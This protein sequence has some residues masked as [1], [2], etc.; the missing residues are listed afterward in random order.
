MTATLSTITGKSRTIAVEPASFAQFTLTDSQPVD[1]ARA[2]A[3]PKWTLYCLDIPSRT[4]LFIDVA[5]G[6]DLA[7]APFA[8]EAQFQH[9]TQAL[10]V[11]FAAFIATA[12]SQDPPEKLLLIFSTG[13]CGSTLFS[14]VLAAMPGV[15][16]LSEPDAFTNLAL[17]GAGLSQGDL[18]DLLKAAMAH[19]FRPPARHRIFAPKFRSEVFSQIPAYTQAFP[20]AVTCF[21]YRDMIGYVNSSYKL[22]QNLGHPDAQIPYEEA[23]SWWAKLSVSSAADGLDHLI[24]D[25]R[26]SVGW[27]VFMA[28]R[29]IERMEGCF[30]AQ[31]DHHPMHMISY[32]DMTTSPNTAFAPVLDACGLSP[33]DL[34]RV[35]DVF[36]R[37]SQSGTVASTRGRAADLSQAQIANLKNLAATNDR[38]QRVQAQ[39]TPQP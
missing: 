39:L 1:A 23:A 22:M 8:Y 6:T 2:L 24:A 4:A 12:K 34:D 11:P 29:W 19:V 15:W 30:A 7:A 26:A 36:A 13:R 14:R 33:D 28:A 17:R 37:D 32:A 20:N 35:A 3:H 10:I 18:Q 9:A 31:N 21:L 38:L 16:S 25:K 27:E 5:K